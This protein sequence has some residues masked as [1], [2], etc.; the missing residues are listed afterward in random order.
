MFHDSAVLLV[1]GRDH[2]T[3]CPHQ[4]DTPFLLP[5]DA[6]RVLDDIGIV[7]DLQQEEIGW[8]DDMALVGH[9]TP[10]LYLSSISHIP[11]T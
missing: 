11:H 4:I 6:V 7:H 5:G 10:Y 1:L 8:L 3:C 2:C 9:L